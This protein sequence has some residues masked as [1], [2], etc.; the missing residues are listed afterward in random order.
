[1]TPYHWLAAGLLVLGAVLVARLIA[2]CD[3]IDRR[4][5]ERGRVVSQKG[6]AA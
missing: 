2:L 1:V 5:Q 3:V 4:R 6:R